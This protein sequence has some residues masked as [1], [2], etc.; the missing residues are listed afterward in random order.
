M[1]VV[2]DSLSQGEE[3]DWTW[4]YRL[5]EWFNSQ[6]LVVDYVGPFLGLRPAAVPWGIGEVTIPEPVG[7]PPVGPAITTAVSHVTINLSLPIP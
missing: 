7:I 5:W 6:E 4:R 3:G 1:M 2:G